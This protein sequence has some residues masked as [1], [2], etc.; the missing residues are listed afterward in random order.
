M[1]VVRRLQTMPT[2]SAV[3]VRGEKH[4][5]ASCPET[6]TVSQGKSIE[7]AIENLKEATELFL[8]ES[9]LPKPSSRAVLTTFEVGHGQG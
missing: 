7:E 9:P 3:V 6:G 1:K 2:L 8:E 4:Y 5:V